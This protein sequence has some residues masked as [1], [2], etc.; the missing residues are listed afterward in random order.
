ML[1]VFETPLLSCGLVLN[2]V[3]TPVV[4]HMAGI[5]NDVPLHDRPV[6]VGGVDDVLI[7]MHDGGVIGKGAAAP[8]AAGK[9]DAPIAVAVVH[10][11]VVADVVAPIAV[12]EAI[13]AVGPAP[14]GRRPQRAW[15]GSRNPGAGNPVVVPIAIRVAPV[16][17]RPHQVGLGAD[18]LLIDRHLR[19]SESDTDGDLRIGRGWNQTEQKRQQKPTRGAEQSHGKN[20]LVLSCLLR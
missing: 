18:R 14:V 19:R 6:N 15:I 16:A 4:G 3:R 12:I 5:G 2:A 11:A 20:L 10:A 17:G 9:T 7:H 13:V 1:F 8:L